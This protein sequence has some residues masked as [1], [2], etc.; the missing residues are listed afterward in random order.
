MGVAIDHYVQK[1]L[2]LDNG[3]AF[4]H[5]DDWYIG[6]DNAGEAED[7]VATLATACRDYELEL[8]AEKTRTLH[9]SSSVDSL[10]PTELR[11]YPFRRNKRR[12]ARSLEHYFTKSFQFAN[13]NPDQNVLDYAVKRTKSLRIFPSNWH[14]YETFLLKAVRSSPLVIPTVVE[15]L[16]SYNYNGYDLGRDRIAKL[17]EDL[18]RKNAPLGHHAEVAWA[19]FLAKALRVKISRRACK[20]VIGLESSVCALLA[21]DLNQNALCEG[22]C[23]RVNVAPIND[24]AGP[25]LTHVASRLR[26]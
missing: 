9:A 26:S 24:A 16:V 5:V 17:I 7:A 2:K 14:S 20:A 3:R 1:T 19:L 18:V 21:L 11:E 12:Q 13:Q 22:T 4:R 6:F 8:N 25:A 10:W 23:E 15:I